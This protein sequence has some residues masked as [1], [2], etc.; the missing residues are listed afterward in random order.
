MYAADRPNALAPRVRHDPAR[1]YVPNSNSDSV[2]VISQ[3][4]GRVV[5]HFA[6]YRTF[7]QAALDATA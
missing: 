6:T 7:L 1:V 4:T 5:D 3:R 2:D